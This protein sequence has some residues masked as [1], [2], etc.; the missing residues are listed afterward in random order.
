[1]PSIAC[2][3]AIKHSISVQIV[4]LFSNDQIFSILGLLYLGIILSTYT[5][6][7]GKAV[8]FLDNVNISFPSSVIPIVCS[9]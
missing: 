9:N 7:I 6:F 2:F 8:L 1:M 4:N 5:S 3:S